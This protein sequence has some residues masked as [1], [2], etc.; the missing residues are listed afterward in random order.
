MPG[1]GVALSFESSRLDVVEVDALIYLV[2]EPE[3]NV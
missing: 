3:S 1:L 2:I